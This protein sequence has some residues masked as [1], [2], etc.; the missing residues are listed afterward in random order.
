MPGTSSVRGVF[1]TKTHHGHPFTI[2]QTNHDPSKIAL[3]LKGSQ[4]AKAIAAGVFVGI[5]TSPLLIVGGVLLGYAT[6]SALSARYK[7]KA[8]NKEQ[9][10]QAPKK[11]ASTEKQPPPPKE[12]KSKETPPPEEVKSKET[13]PPVKIDTSLQEHVEEKKDPKSAVSSAKEQKEI[14]EKKL[15]K[16]TKPVNQ[17][18]KR[19]VTRTFQRINADLAKKERAF[20]ELAVEICFLVNAKDTADFNL[21]AYTSKMNDASKLYGEIIEDKKERGRVFVEGNKRAGRKKPEEEVLRYQAEAEYVLPEDFSIESHVLKVIE[22]IQER[23]RKIQDGHAQK[24]EAERGRREVQEITQ[25]FF[26]CLSGK[27]GGLLYLQEQLFSQSQYHPSEV[28]AGVEAA[29]KAMKAETAANAKMLAITTD[30]QPPEKTP[31][32]VNIGIKNYGNTCWL[33][34]LLK[35]MATTEWGN[36]FCSADLEDQAPNLQSFQAQL[37]NLLANL[38]TEKDPKGQFFANKDQIIQL[39]N[40]LIALRIITE[41]DIGAQLDAKEIFTMLCAQFPLPPQEDRAIRK[42]QF[43]SSAAPQSENLCFEPSEVDISS[44]VIE[45]PCSGLKAIKD[46]RYIPVEGSDA[47]DLRDDEETAIANLCEE[48]DTVDINRI[49]LDVNDGVNDDPIL[50]TPIR[51][52]V[53]NNSNSQKAQFSALANDEARALPVKKMVLPIGLPPK[54]TL[55]YNPTVRIGEINKLQEFVGITSKIP[56]PFPVMQKGSNKVV[57][58]H[59]YDELNLDDPNSPAYT[60]DGPQPARNCH[61]RIKGAVIHIGERVNVGH[62][63]YLE[64][65]ANGTYKYHNDELI[66]ILDPKRP[67]DDVRINQLLTGGVLFELELI[68]KV[69]IDK[70]GRTHPVPLTASTRKAPAPKKIFEKRPAQKKK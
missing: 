45:V 13:P 37:R 9:Q 50:R 22:N 60:K 20:D 42:Q 36:A 38:H 17:T 48:L 51:K 59:E 29:L 27:K 18:K 6:F 53:A 28:A 35:F 16:E 31:P 58:L 65:L 39:R 25:I 14:S 54:I 32:P 68:E 33:N 19:P 5:A 64:R 24:K 21:A 12:V 41:N 69:A 30:A 63:T 34:S 49:I 44:T 56:L 55:S 57:S 2:P 70:D 1:W 23:E 10:G 4:K 61:Y 3:E 46:T 11:S 47:R 40:S 7:V 15:P 52:L 8:L 26:D 67:Q 62:Y 43:F 66:S